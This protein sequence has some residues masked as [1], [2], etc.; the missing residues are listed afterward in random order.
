MNIDMSR[1]ITAEAKAAETLAAERSTLTCSR[2]QGIL[3][4]GEA[5]WASVLA[6]RETASWAEQII[7][8]SAGDWQRNSEN[9]QFFAYLLGLTDDEVD[10]LFRTARALTA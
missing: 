6:Y 1:I 9:I 4:L 5:R 3:A 8:D 2:M 10:D 7:I